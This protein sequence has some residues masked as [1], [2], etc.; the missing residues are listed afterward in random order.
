MAKSP[1]FIAE[2]LAVL[3]ANGGNISATSRA[4]GVSRTAIREWRDREMEK[5]RREAVEDK[6]QD[7]TKQLADGLERVALL[8]VGLVNKEALEKQT[9]YYNMKTAHTAMQTAALLRGDLPQD[10]DPIDDLLKR[11]GTDA[12]G[13]PGAAYNAPPVA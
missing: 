9:A 11:F 7:K 6:V 8:A 4:T 10:D 13:E 5:G 12:Y 2:T 3:K 1:D